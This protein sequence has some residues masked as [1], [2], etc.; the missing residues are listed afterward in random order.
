MAE[1]ENII[2]HEKTKTPTRALTAAAVLAAKT[3]ILAK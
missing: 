1:K 3:M 2:C